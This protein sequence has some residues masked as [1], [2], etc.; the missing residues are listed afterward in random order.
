MNSTISDKIC[1][2]A[3]RLSFI[4]QCAAIRACCVFCAVVAVVTT[5]TAQNEDIPAR[6]TP[7]I[8]TILT[9]LDSL[10]LKSSEFIKEK[11]SRIESFHRKLDATGNLEQR[12]WLQSSLYEE[13][14]AYDSD[15]AMKYADEALATAK[16]LGRTDLEDE[17]NLNRVYLLSATGFLEKA[18]E[19]LG[20]IDSAQ[21]SPELALKYCDR[22]LF[23]STHTDLY[24]GVEYEMG[25]YSQMA[26]SILHEM[27]KD[28]R[29]GDSNY[30]WLTGW[31][32][33]NDKKKAAS[34]IPILRKTVDSSDNATRDF[35]MMA[36]V[37]AKLYEQIG[38]KQNYL[39]YLLS[40]AMADI[41]ACNKEI[42]SLEEASKIL[43]DIGDLDHANQYVNYCI[44]CANDYKSRVRTGNLARLQKDILQSIQERSERQ[45]RINHIYMVLLIVI[46]AV[47]NASIFYIMRQNKL[48]KQSRATLNEANAEL[49]DK[50]KAL[51]AIRAQLNET[52]EKL[53]EMYQ[54]AKCNAKELADVNEEKERHIAD[55]FAICSN[56]INKMDDFRS[57]I[58][59]LLVDK[60]FDKV[61]D[62][63]KSPELSYDEIKELYETFD[64]IFLNI[65]PGFVE[66]FNTLLRP[67]ERITLRNPKTLNTELRIYALVRLGLNDSVKI[68]KFLHC[69]VQTVYNTRQRTRN[70]A[71][72]SREQFAETVRKLGRIEN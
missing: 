42:A 5:A 37:L 41:R 65:Y 44:A 45:I 36:W 67:E 60:K 20:S 51:S 70:K 62:I 64:E 63:V 54:T 53:Q 24:I 31:S 59:R 27:T 72:V 10:L 46:I 4:A 39:K 2:V 29:E 23:L 47:I 50:V 19:V 3:V 33:L 56:Y 58:H 52:N 14:S 68:A 16:Q 7:E 71:A 17:M 26:D 35:A 21:L 49:N 6:L 15:F 57:N 25:M 38:D 61:L 9:D 48:L 40:S 12:Y 32:S 69:S 34:A 66:D 1:G 18:A 43:Y 22:M 8:K 30:Y 11:E 13:Y 28:L 55:M